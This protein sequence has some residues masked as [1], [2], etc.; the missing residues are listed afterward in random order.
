[1]APCAQA[2]HLTAHNVIQLPHP[3]G[4]KQP[5]SRGPWKLCP[6][7]CLAQCSCSSACQQASVTNTYS[8]C[9]KFSPHVTGVQ[10]LCRQAGSRR[11]KCVWSEMAPMGAHCRS[12]TC[13]VL[14]LPVHAI[15]SGHQQQ[16]DQHLQPC[17]DKPAV[18]CARAG[19]QCL[20]W[21]CMQ[22]RFCMAAATVG[23]GTLLLVHSEA[24][25]LKEGR[26]PDWFSNQWLAQEGGSLIDLA[27]EGG[28]AATA[29]E[30]MRCCRQRSASSPPSCRDSVI[31]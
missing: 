6:T 17:T 16:Q 8:A 24:P 20:T 5:G 13:M 10:A 26:K 18:P 12:S 22:W 19:L 15:Q 3:S 9:S 2:Q 21:R 7:G 23:M 4:N 11:I 28:G 14:E 1:M 29:C 30:I 27:Q 25:L 31:P